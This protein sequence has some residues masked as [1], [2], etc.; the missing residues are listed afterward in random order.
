MDDIDLAYSCCRVE[1][2]SK[3]VIETYNESSV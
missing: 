1:L 3:K 2:L